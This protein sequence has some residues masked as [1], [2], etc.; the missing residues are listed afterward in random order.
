MKQ[1]F[2]VLLVLLGVQAQAAVTWC[3]QVL[4]DTTPWATTP[5]PPYIQIND[6][7]GLTGEYVAQSYPAAADGWSYGSL[8]PFTTYRL[9]AFGFN[10]RASTTYQG[11]FA[12]TTGADGSS[13]KFEVYTGG[14]RTVTGAPGC[15]PPVTYP[16]HAWGQTLTNTEAFVVRY[17]FRIDYETGEDFEDIFSLHPGEVRTLTVEN[18]V[19]FTPTIDVERVLPDGLG[20][21]WVASTGLSAVVTTTPTSPPA[22]VNTGSTAAGNIWNSTTAPTQLGTQTPIAPT[23]SPRDDT[24]SATS[25]ALQ[26][27]I[28][29][30]SDKR[31]AELKSLLIAADNAQAKRDTVALQSQVMGLDRVSASVAGLGTGASGSLTTT[32]RTGTGSDFA[33]DAV[34]GTANNSALGELLPTLGSPGT[35]PDLTFTFPLSAFHADLEDYVL[36]FGNEHLSGWVTVFRT[37]ALFVV[38]GSML[39]ASFKIFGRAGN[40]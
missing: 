10:G 21:V 27:L 37:F 2:A 40:V 14:I 22:A 3:F 6:N 12:F 33:G 17:R 15:S 30:N 32:G 38:T 19:N 23:A 36:D 4:P 28:D 25:D 18:T 34:S 11:P 31:H 9:Y 24:S 1:V 20:T 29:G 26:R 35:S 8:A 7:T 39:F 13:V 5:Y 16:K